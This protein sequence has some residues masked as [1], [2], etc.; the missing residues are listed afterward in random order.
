LA[1]TGLEYA[2]RDYL[3]RVADLEGL[4]C[5]SVLAQ[6]LRVAGVGAPDADRAI[7]TADPRNPYTGASFGWDAAR[8]VLLIDGRARGSRSRHEVWL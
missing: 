3:F 6:S 5:G 1:S 4:R 8:S 2:L 7:E